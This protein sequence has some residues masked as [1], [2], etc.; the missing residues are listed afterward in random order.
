MA[1]TATSRETRSL[2]DHIDAI[3]ECVDRSLEDPETL[4]LARQVVSG[5]FDLGVD[6]RTRRKVPVVRYHGRH[7]LAAPDWSHA[8]FVC[9]PKDNRCEVTAIWNFVVLNV[10]YV[11]DPAGSDTYADLRTILESGGGDCDEF[12]IAFAALL[13]ALGYDVKARVISVDGKYWAHIYPMV[14][15]GRRW[16]A[17]DATENG[18]PMGWEYPTPAEVRDYEL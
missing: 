5:S 10:R 11:S 17:L 15:L 9:R 12:T 6:P 16:L 7:Y 4:S 8:R 3:A 13:K 14:R 18:K 2:R 1:A